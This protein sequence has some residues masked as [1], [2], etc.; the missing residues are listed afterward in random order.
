MKTTA[1]SLVLLTSIG[2]SA[3]AQSMPLQTTTGAEL[4][5]QISS[6]RYEEDSNGSFFMALEG[7]KLGLTGSFTQ[8]YG[9]NWYWGADARYASGNADYTSAGTG[10]KS[11]NPDVYFD[12]RITVGRDFEVASQLLSPYAGLG[13]RYLNNDLR[14]YSTTG[15]AGYRRTSKYT[16]LPLGVTHRFR[17]GKEARWAT[18][19][20]YD[21]LIE[22]VQRSY[23]TDRPTGGFDSDLINQQRNGYGLRLNLA[24]ET[25]GWSA[26]IF[27][28]YWNIA[29]SDRGV[30]TSPGFVYT[31]YEPHNITREVGVQLKY[32]FR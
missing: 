32:R 16:Y 14:G 9:D 2:A 20:E 15:A 1:L 4:G 8:T 21:Y 10:D 6:Y 25:P 5:I 22:G 30:Y 7:K 23:M 24:Y 29:D 31:G 28:H 27:Y 18:T 19:L 12:T 26:G 13:Y 3:H 11:A 17:I